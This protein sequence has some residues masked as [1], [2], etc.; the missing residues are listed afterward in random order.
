[1]LL[2]PMHS[3]TRFDFESSSFDPSTGQI[4]LRYS[5]DGTILFTETLLIPVDA[6]QP[7]YNAD[8][9]DRALSYLHI[10]GG[11]SYYKTCCPKE[12]VLRDGG[13]TADQAAYWNTVYEKGLGEF[14]YKNKINFR[15]L[16]NFPAEKTELTPIPAHTPTPGTRPK[17]LVPIGGGKDS[18]VTVELLKSARHRPTLLRVGGHPLIQQAAA[19]TGL[20]LLVVERHLSPTLF[21]LNA[22]GAYN[23]HV[24]ITGYLSWLGVVVAI[25]TGHDAVVWS[26]ERSASEGNVEYLGSEINH[27]WSKSVEAERLFQEQ[28]ARHVTGGVQSFSLLRPWSELRIAEEFCG[29]IDYF[30]CATSCNENWK[31][32]AKNKMSWPADRSSAQRSGGWC[33]K[34]PKCAFS[35]LLFAAYLPREI[36]KD[37]V[38]HDCLADESLLPLYE[39]LL[40][41]ERFKPFECVG[42][43]EESKAALVLAH[44]KGD[45]A[46]TPVMQLFHDRVLS[47]I[48]DPDAL[49]QELRTPS[50]DHA[51]PQAYLGLVS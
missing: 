27:Q 26:N 3:H 31:I 18:L 4:E 1:M 42:T 36:V 40:G 23:G 21:T 25:I 16:I 14:F 33:G 37:M 38:G 22:K 51:V 15:G 34:C 43:P 17:L 50:T 44:R 35:S 5:L 39:E 29:L 32:L 19:V 41:L 45:Y 6:I 8:A 10:A 20:D 28:L 11:I 2:V 13:L 7:D 24:P 47:T 30:S 12:I 48:A 49:L 9:L 46:K